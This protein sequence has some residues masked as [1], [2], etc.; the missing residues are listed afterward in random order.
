MRMVVQTTKMN[1]KEVHASTPQSLP[2]KCRFWN[3]NEGSKSK[4]KSG[5]MALLKLWEFPG[6]EQNSGHI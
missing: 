5:M 6:S 2:F 3:G 1:K 4:N